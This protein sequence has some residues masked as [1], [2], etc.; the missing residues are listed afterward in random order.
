MA[1]RSNVFAPQEF[2]EKLRRD[3]L[4]APLALTGM[5]KEAVDPTHLLFA[6]GSRCDFWTSIPLDL[7]EK[8]EL[9]DRVACGDHTHQLVNLILKTQQLPETAVFASLLHASLRQRTPAGT[10]S[11]LPSTGGAQQQRRLI[12]FARY[13]RPGSAGSLPTTRSACAECND[14]EIVDGVGIGSLAYCNYYPSG[15]VLCWYEYSS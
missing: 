13:T 15:L 3:E 11:H 5:V 7:I 8:I 10:A 2:I 1:E 14:Y 4:T 9:V 6:F 12:P